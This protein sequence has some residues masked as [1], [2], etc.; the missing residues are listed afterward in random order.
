MLNRECPAC[1]KHCTHDEA[2]VVRGYSIV[3][4]HECGLGIAVMPR[5]A[6]AIYDVGVFRGSFTRWLHGLC[7][8]RT[9]AEVGVC[10]A[11]AAFL[12]FCSA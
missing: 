2:Y 1:T 5:D 3:R 8:E 10:R 11:R 7:S 4:C 6:S 12:S 9:R